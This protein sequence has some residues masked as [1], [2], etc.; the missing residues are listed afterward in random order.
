MY[1]KIGRVANDIEVK[2]A[3]ASKV[4]R[5]SLAVRRKYQRDGKAVTDFVP[6]EVWGKL[7][8]TMGQHVGKGQMI[9]I[10]GELENDA[11]TDKEGKRRDKWVIK[12][13]SFEFAGPK[14]DGAGGNA[15]VVEDD[16]AD[17]PPF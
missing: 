17:F 4:G 6:C 1:T 3:G 5:F 12:V 7:A 14:P 11:F 16:E 2:D 10:E 9:Y 15:P 8:E 13:S